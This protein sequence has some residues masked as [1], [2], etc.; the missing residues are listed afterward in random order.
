MA[1]FET[2][3]SRRE[4]REEAKGS[5]RILIEILNLN[6]PLLP[7]TLGIPEGKPFSHIIG[8]PQREIRRG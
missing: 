5:I 4:A 1:A 3:E 6:A 7:W 8:E 2:A